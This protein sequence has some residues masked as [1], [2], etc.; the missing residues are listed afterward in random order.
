MVADVSGDRADRFDGVAQ[1]HWSDALH[2][3][4]IPI[5]LDLPRE[6]HVLL[7]PRLPV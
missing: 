7:S 1:R 6:R 5:V 4:E 3:G 2:I